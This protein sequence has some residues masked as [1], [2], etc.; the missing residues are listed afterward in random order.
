VVR[1]GAK[2]APVPCSRYLED[3][4]IPLTEDIV[5]AA[6]KLVKGEI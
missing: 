5:E 3:N 6:R 1:L 4:S 2:D